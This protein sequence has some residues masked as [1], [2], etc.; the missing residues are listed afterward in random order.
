MKHKTN[1]SHWRLGLL[2]LGCAAAP[3]LPQPLL[4]EVSDADFKA[5][6]DLVQQLNDQVQ[7][8]RQTN[9]LVQ[10]QHQQDVQQLKELQTKLAETQQTATDAQQKSEAAVQAQSQPQSR[11]PL[12]EATVNRNFQILGDAEFQYANVD[13]Q[14]G[15]FLLADFAPIFLYRG[16]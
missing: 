3:L 15:A 8:L 1:S 5:L 16:G 14:H 10:Q 2:A 6:K 11:A 9:Q 7:S 12:D 13:H 4:A